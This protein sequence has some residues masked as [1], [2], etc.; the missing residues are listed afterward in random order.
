[1]KIQFTLNGQKVGV[2]TPAERS[3]LDLLREL[4]TTSLKRGCDDEGRCGACSV[5]FDGKLV[6]ACLLCAGQLEGRDVQT[7]E[8]LAPHGELHPVQQ[9]FL[10][11]GIVQCGYCTPAMILAIKGLLDRDPN[12][13]REAVRDSVAGIYCRCTGYELL[14]QTAN[15]AAARIANP[16]ATTEVPR[17]RDDLRVVGKAA[18]R[19]DGPS[20]VRGERVFVEDKVPADALFVKVLRSPHP[21]ARVERIDVSEAEKVPGV[22]HVLTGENGPKPL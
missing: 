18:V 19:V 16:E 15:L 13:T 9:A 21:H 20:L 7:V 1:M 17:F 2:D 12:P 10:E 5:L 22:V 4:G 8:G 3:A 11:T 6:R 14:Y